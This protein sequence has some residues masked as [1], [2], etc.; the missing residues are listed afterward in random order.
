MF[1]GIKN[2]LLLLIVQALYVQALYL[3]P[4]PI[5]AQTIQLQFDTTA[6]SSSKKWHLD[7]KITY[8]AQFKDSLQ[9]FSMGIVDYNKNGKIELDSTDLIYIDY[10]GIDYF[11][12]ERISSSTILTKNTI[13]ESEDIQYTIES[14]DPVKSIMILS[15]CH[16]KENPDI[17]KF[18]DLPDLPF[19]LYPDSVSS[20]KQFLKKDKYL[21]VEIW[22]I[23]CSPCI[24]SF[25]LLNEYQAKY[26]DKLTILT[27]LDID[28]EKD[29][30][31]KEIASKHQ[32]NNVFTQGYSTAEINTEFNSMGYPN[33]FLFD[34]KGKLIERGGRAKEMLLL[35]ESL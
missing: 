27:L 15:P 1:D 5:T 16:S 18:N 26:S 3:T 33:Y 34:D 31:W 29:K 22:S 2:Y 21:L 11:S 10:Y 28:F 24:K 20:L 13:V 23:T 8:S 14:F 4:L 17:Q 12:N 7:K 19:H 32:K 6:F 30:E 25:P 35:F 9:S